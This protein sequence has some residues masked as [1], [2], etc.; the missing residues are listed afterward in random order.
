MSERAARLHE[1][2]W[3]GVFH[4][5]GGGSGFLAEMLSVPGA[6]RTVLE[7]R[8]PYAE[9]AL[10]RLL[11]AQPEQACSEATARALAMAAFQEALRLSWA[12][13]AADRESTL[14]GFACTASLATDRP[15]RG[16]HRAH[17][18][19]QTATDTWTL[20][21]DFDGNRQEEE[22]ALVEAIWA[23]LGSALGLEDRA[24]NPEK[25]SGQRRRTTAP[26]SWQALILGDKLAH[27]TSEHAGGLL[28]PGAFNPLH[29]GHRKML[30]IAEAL[31][32]LE[33]AFE[34][35][36]ANV[37]KPMLDYRE[38]ERRLAQFDRPVWLTHLPTFLEKAR[39]FPGATFAIGLDTLLRIAEPVYYASP[40]G[41]QAALEELEALG[42][43][44]VVFG[45]ERDDRFLVL[46]D[47]AHTLPQHLTA[48]CVGVDA[49]TF[50]DAVSSTVLRRSSD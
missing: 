8:V 25:Q 11:G 9:T 27:A 2:P 48:R 24:G 36:V 39:H 42:T 5:T 41:M 4:V 45:R 14:F 40:A 6:S 44:F 13:P 12:E 21:L 30:D 29:R 37:D 19:V 7:A 18:A 23:E 15:K 49:A 34:L 47:V 50:R 43:Q 10:A 38:I 1:S 35:S 3:R 16:A 46:E 20:A 33:G 26:D 31:T 17:V 28:L 22:A 32:G